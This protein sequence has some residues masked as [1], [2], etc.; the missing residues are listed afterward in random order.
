MSRLPHFKYFS[1]FAKCVPEVITSNVYTADFV[2]DSKLEGFD[3]FEVEGIGRGPMR[4][5]QL[6]DVVDEVRYTEGVPFAQ[7]TPSPEENLAVGYLRSPAKKASFELGDLK[8]R[9]RGKV[10]IEPSPAAR[11]MLTDLLNRT[12][13]QGLRRDLWAGGSHTFYPKTPEDLNRTYP[14]C[15]L[16]LFRGPFYRYNVN[17]DGKFT[18]TLDSS[19]HYADSKPF[20]ERLRTPSGID[21]FARDI[22]GMRQ[23]DEQ[24]GRKFRGIHFFY[25]LATMDVGVDDVDMRPISQIPMDNPTPING[26]IPKNV[27]DFL[28]LRYEKRSDILR[29]EDS[30]PGL[31]SRGLAY[32]PQFLHRT[33]NNQIIPDKI[34]NE[35]TFYMDTGPTGYRDLQKPARKRMEIIAD[36]FKKFGFESI[37]LGSKLL[38]FTGPNE[39]SASNR[40]GKPRLEIGGRFITDPTRVERD[41][42][43]GLYRP[44]RISKVF[45]YSIIDRDSTL[46]FYR[47]LVESA[48]RR[49]RVRLPQ[50]PVMLEKDVHDMEAQLANSVGVNGYE[51]CFGIGII[52][53]DSKSLHDTLTSTWG[54]LK[55]P[56]KCVTVPVVAAV[57]QEGKSFHLKDTL[58]SI[59][60]RA[61]GVPWVLNDRLHYGCYAAVDVG[62]SLSDWWA[63]GI[64]Y[65]QDGTFTAQPGR[66]IRGEDLDE[67]SLRH[68]IGV[69][70]KHAPRSESLIYLR[71][72][73]VH[74]TERAMFEKVI[75]QFPSYKTIGIVSVKERVPYR[76][77]RKQ[78]D[79]LTKP[80][81]GDFYHLDKNNVVLC[82]AGWDE[83]QH[84][85]PQPVVAEI[86]SV[87]GTLEEQKVVE[88][89]FRLCYLNWG[90]PGRSYSIPA[91]IRLADE[92][93]RE[94]GA[95]IRR[96]GPPF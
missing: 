40:Y 17:A 47:Q 82:A 83:Y 91:P 34:Q 73:D 63:M 48:Y 11:R 84:G 2:F 12:K 90:S 46:E 37:S 61:R 44:P 27:A 18:L 77:F 41:L 24:T 6:G 64:V 10:D 68:C 53:G 25:T 1:P 95:G 8:V 5:R 88:D 31:K 32:A 7:Y 89:C 58:A 87:R 66:M 13:Y 38:T 57:V 55:I 39:Y 75:A 35:Q 81:S 22:A 3:C 43:N 69:A 21:D 96:Y 36:Y 49:Y 51:G 94:L 79:V 59:F 14:G 45:L 56:S 29:L 19:T 93:A 9:Y 54:D 30:Q 80:L 20:L 78:G 76:I 85:T 4:Y 74:E 71:Q 60:A 86:I 15:G 65:T 16:W 23:F 92:M 67:A 28:R 72:G 33:V 42:R 70:N 52:P 26:V 62:R 50:R